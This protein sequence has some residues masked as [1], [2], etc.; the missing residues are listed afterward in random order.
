MKRILSLLMAMLMIGVL[1]SCFPGDEEDV[2]NIDPTAIPPETVE[3]LYS[4]YNQVE[5]GMTRAQIEELFGEGEKKIDDDG[6]ET[7]ISYK[8]EKKSAGVNIIYAYDDTVSAKTLYYN[9]IKDLIPFATRFDESR[10]SEIKEKMPVSAAV[11]L[12][13]GEGLEIVC[14]YSVNSP[15]EYG[16][17]YTWINEDGTSFQLYTNKEIIDQP[18]LSVGPD[19]R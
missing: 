3:E 18:V 1:C 13:G 16:K 2:I 10:I 5:R 19:R 17:V 8:N 4:Y 6:V 9:H 15:T 7:F 14:E 12:F 11:E